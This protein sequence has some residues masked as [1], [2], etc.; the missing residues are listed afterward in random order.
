[1]IEKEYMLVTAHE[2]YRAADTILRDAWLPEDK[3]LKR[4]GQEIAFGIRTMMEEL[5]KRYEVLPN[6]K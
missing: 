1:M 6:P 3:A 5:E 2:L 4:L